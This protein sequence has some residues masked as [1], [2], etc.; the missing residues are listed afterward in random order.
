MEESGDEEGDLWEKKVLWVEKMPK[1][2]QRRSFLV[3]M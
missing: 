3:R 1:V 2:Y